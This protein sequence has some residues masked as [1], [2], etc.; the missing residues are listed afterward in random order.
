LW[1]SQFHKN[2]QHKHN[3]INITPFGVLGTP[4]GNT[5]GG[6]PC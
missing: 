3:N 1:L 2:C 4:P 6:C 5:S